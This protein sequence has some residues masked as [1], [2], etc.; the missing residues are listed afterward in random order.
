MR[1]NS[2]IKPFTGMVI[3]Q[4]HTRHTKAFKMVRYKILLKRLCQVIERSG[5]RCSIIK[6][7]DA[8]AHREYKGWITC[9]TSKC[10]QR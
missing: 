6:A 9:K 4:M 8:Y 7:P 5:L 3:P 10:Q 1:F 2:Q